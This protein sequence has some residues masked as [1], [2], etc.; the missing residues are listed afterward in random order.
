MPRP[1]KSIVEDVLTPQ[2]TRRLWTVNYYPALPITP[3]AFEIGALLP[4]MLYMARFGHRRG[5]GYFVK[6]FGMKPNGDTV[7]PTISDVVNGLLCR[8]G[9]AIEGCDDKVGQSVLGDLLLAWCLE[10]S[11]H[12]EGHLEQVQRIYP[13]HYLASWI[14]LPTAVSH[15]RGVPELLTAL[16]AQQDSGEWIE[17]HGM[18]RFPVGVT[19]PENRLLAL[20]SRNMQIRGAH[21]TDLSSDAFVEAGAD[22]IG[23]DELLAIRMAQSCGSAPLKA[24]GKDESERI[25]NR[26]PLARRAADILREDL[27]VFI[28]V[29]GDSV[30]RQVFLQMLESGI[31][32]AL[33][34]LL[35]STARVLTEWERTGRVPDS[36]RQSPWPLF[37]DASHGQDKTLRDLSEESTTEALR[38][39]ERLPVN[40][41]I[42]R[43][44]DDR[45]G[46]DLKLGGKLPSA[47]PEPT[48]FV[49]ALGEI[50]H[51]HHPRAEFILENFHEDCLRLANGLEAENETPEI[52]R[53]LRSTDTNPLVR[54][55]EAL[56]ELMGDKLQRA[57]FMKALEDAL[58]T[59]RPNGLAIKRRVSRQQNGERRSQD[60]RSVVFTPALLD[61]LVH[62]HLRKAAE[63][64]PF[65]PLSLPDFLTLLRDRYGLYV[66]RE[67]PGQLVSQEL[68]RRNKA[69]FERRLRDLGLLIGVNDAESMKQLRPR[70][71]VENGDAV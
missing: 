68:L 28:E 62:R 44:L 54:L 55:A 25:P 23:I 61:F 35:L 7:P 32:I 34:N 18:G 64:K 6:T 51:G 63:G 17:T 1:V 2:R 20:F 57:Q 31:G 21:G 12:A 26:H 67:P 5:R 43:I 36:A 11:K 22:D 56:C 3:T 37:V 48:A 15:L 52:A 24:K 59:D 65:H 41:M 66:D 27:L 33:A 29:Y 14:D 19:H 9:S 71:Q 10:N 47:A 50:F 40:M 42:L 46:T 53:R 49:D 39:Y 45:V 8:P 38:C 58:M 60:L 13:T 70:F 4:A 69:W 16:L 30:P